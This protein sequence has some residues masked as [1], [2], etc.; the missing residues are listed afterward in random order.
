[1]I[2]VAMLGGCVISYEPIGDDDVADTSTDEAD[3]TGDGDTATTD[4]GDTTDATDE[5]DTVDGNPTDTDS[6][7]DTDTDT[8]DETDSTGDGDGDC[9]QP[10]YPNFFDLTIELDDEP[11]GANLD[12]DLACTVLEDDTPALRL[13]CT[14]FE[15][16]IAPEGELV[17]E[18]PDPTGA[19]V[20]VRLITEDGWLTNQWWLRLDYQGG[21]KSVFVIDAITIEPPAPTSWIPPWGLAVVDE[22]AAN[23]NRCGDWIGQ[24]VG[25]AWQDQTLELLHGQSGDL[26]DMGDAGLRMWNERSW[27]YENI[28]PT[29]DTPTSWKKIAIVG[30]QMVEGDT[31]TPGESDPCGTGL[32][33][34]YPCGI[35]DCNHVCTPEDPETMG[36]PPPPP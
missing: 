4:D 21:A 10:Q 14:Q 7:S 12:L 25:I 24:T 20:H 8:T 28:E 32:E 23:N 5:A 1:V 27:R 9:S 19:T 16:S 17:G 33:C 22:C 18:I 30:N 2:A 3:T 11:I 36:C 34:C 29:C 15:L 6:D 31:C 26:G 13:G 35:P